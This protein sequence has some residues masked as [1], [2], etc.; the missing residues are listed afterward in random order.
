M[1]GMIELVKKLF[2]EEEKTPEESLENM[3]LADELLKLCL[4]EE[5]FRIPDKDK[6]KFV[7]LR[8][9]PVYYPPEEYYGKH[10][11]SPAFIDMMKKYKII[12][13]TIGNVHVFV[14]W[15]K[16]KEEFGFGYALLWKHLFETYHIVPTFKDEE[17]D[18]CN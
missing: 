17:E 5:G 13:I 16:A 8:D 9:K 4:V 15:K 14:T 18:G 11:T 12:P 7:V 3:D 6:D 2:A 1:K 10:L